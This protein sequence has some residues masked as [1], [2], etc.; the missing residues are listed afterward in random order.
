MTPRL[1][2]VAAATAAGLLAGVAVDRLAP[3]PAADVLRGSEEAFAAGLEWRELPVTRKLPRRWTKPH[4]FFRF[5]NLPPGPASLEVAVRQH[6]RPVTVKVNGA[7]LAE[8]PPGRSAL[9]FDLGRLSDSTLEIELQTEPTID[10]DGRALGTRLDRVGLRHSRGGW[11]PLSLLLPFGMLAFAATVVALG[12]GLE[13]VTAGATGAALAGLMGLLLLPCGLARSGYAVELPALLLISLLMASGLARWSE[14]RVPGAGPWAFA[15]GLSTT[16]VQGV[17][18]VSPLLVTSD[19]G[20][21]AHNLLDVSRGEF[22]LTSVTPHARPFRIPYGISF[23]L[24]LAPFVGRGVDAVAL[25]RWGAAASGVAA[26]LGLFASLLRRSPREAGLAVVLLQL[27]PVSFVYYSEGTLSNVFGQSLTTLFFAW[28]AA[29]AP[30]GA[31]LGG[32][33]LGAGGTAH[34]SS[35]VVL[36]VLTTTLLALRRGDARLD[37]RRLLAAVLGLGTAAA[38]YAAFSGMILE[39]LPRMLEGPG[40][41]GATPFGPW[42]A[43]LV[44]VRAV[45]A[46]LGLPALYLALVGRPRRGRGALERDLS[47]LWLTGGFLCAVS[48]ATPLEVRYAYAAAPAV[49]VAAGGALAGLWTAGPGGRVMATALVAGQAVLAALGLWQALLL[50]YRP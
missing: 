34:L 7:F 3:F 1:L 41:G 49:A 23:Y 20:F 8:I 11:P 31:A 45:G 25:V 47:A 29:G 12:A 50:R 6:R 16:L 21:H 30:F 32:L 15:A 10:A 39:Q 44:Q 26:S 22:L 40:R 28:W 37:R 9:Q 17:A 42:Q 48:L 36:V 43:L 5:R 33:L 14:T 24:A 2:A 18:A 19:A 46:G 38:Y 35:F 13:A 4:A 27:L